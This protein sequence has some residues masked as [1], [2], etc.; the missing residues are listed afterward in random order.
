MQPRSQAI[1]N[2]CSCLARQIKKSSFHV[3]GK[4]CS[5]I[6]VHHNGD[7][8]SLGAQAYEFIRDAIVFLKFEPGQ[9]VYEAEIANMLGMSRTP[10]REAFQKL[11]AEQLLAVLPQRG[12]KIS[13]ISMEKVEEVRFVRE[14]LEV[15]SFRKVAECWN[16]E[17]KRC[18]AAKRE[19]M[20]SLDHQREAALERDHAAFLQWD[21]AFHHHILSV[22]GNRTLMMMVSVIRGH[23]NRLR[24]LT[25]KEFNDMEELLDDHKRLFE[26]VR[27]NNVRLTVRL[28]ERHLRKVSAR[29][30][31]VYRRFPHYFE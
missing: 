12:V 19:I 31:H 22:T 27:T 2:D 1:R 4:G 8:K 16:D 21:E 23:L 10:V 29:W 14:S 7:R 11:F 24:Y 17:D 30:E 18:K 3:K 20:R 15:S 25:L 28:L 13:L 9:M 26:A 5:E 6:I